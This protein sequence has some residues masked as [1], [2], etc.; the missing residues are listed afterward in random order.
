MTD[1]W[2]PILASMTGE[3]DSGSYSNEADVREPNFQQTFFG[4]NYPRLRS[5]KKL[6]D[7]NSLF[8]VGA[9]VGSEEWDSDGICRL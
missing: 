4:P 5:I 6:Y 3:S 9:G 7:P 1:I 8:I 2:V